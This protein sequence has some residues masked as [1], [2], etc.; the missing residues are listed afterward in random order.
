MLIRGLALT[1][2]VGGI[3]GAAY[4]DLQ[5]VTLGGSIEVGAAWYSEL[6]SRAAEGIPWIPDRFLPQRPIGPYGTR[7]FFQSHGHGPSLF[8]VEQR[9]RLRAQADFTDEVKGLI[10]IDSI[11]T[12]GDDLRTDYRVGLDF[13]ADSGDDLEIFQGYIE[14]EELGGLPLR[15]R[16]GRQ[17]MTYGSGWLVGANP[18]PDPFTGLSFDAVRLTYAAD[19][20]TVD[21][22]AGKVVET[23]AAEEDGD[24]DFCGLYGSY[25]GLERLTLDAYWMLVRDARRL[26]DTDLDWPVERLE[27]WMGYDDYDPTELHTVGLRAAGTLGAFEF[28]AE[29]AYQFGNADAVG[30]LFRVGD[31]GDDRARYDGRWGANLELGYSFDRSL[32]PFVYLT[33]AYFSG[34]DN[35]RVSLAD[36]LN[37]FDRPDASVS[38]NRLFSDYEYD[39]FYDTSAFSN[40]WLVQAGIAINPT[41]KLELSTD[42]TY[43]HA[44]GRFDRPVSVSLGD[45]RL[46]LAPDLAFLT[47]SGSGEL[48]WEWGVNASY[49]YSEN[50]TIHVGWAHLFAGDALEDGAFVDEHGLRNVGGNGNRDADYLY[51][52]IH[53]HFRFGEGSDE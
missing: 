24:V 47:Q 46:F 8:F 9:T 53:I 16:V 39:Y 30:A 33:G 12:W 7:S 36:W 40:W 41:E 22:W 28:N 35:R 2:L 4:A 14:A 50:L 51:S 27:G 25:T 32:A 45:G 42:L 19:S 20:F 34:E 11:E 13:P 3:A 48:G 49:A 18:D 6:W 1:A 23:G 37:P 38:F 15:L 10:E 5:N 44:V 52:H 21:A 43:A 17:A 29:A 31:Y 26:N